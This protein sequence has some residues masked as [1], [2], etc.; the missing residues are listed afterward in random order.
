[1]II[2]KQQ[3]SFIF[4]EQDQHARISESMIK[5]WNKAYLPQS[6][7]HDSAIYAIQQHDVGWR[8]FDEEPFW[9]DQSQAPYNFTD[10]PTPAKTV[11]YTAGIE[12][13]ASADLYAGLLCSLHYTRFLEKDTSYYSKQFVD[14][15]RRRQQ[16]IISSLKQFDEE[17]L[18]IHLDLLQL[19]DNLS[20]FICLNKPGENT[21]PFFKNGIPLSAKLKG[22]TNQLLETTWQDKQTIQLSQL[23]FSSATTFTYPYK[24]VTKTAIYE[25][26]LISTYTQAPIK[27]IAVTF[28]QG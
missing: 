18:A 7:Y 5:H 24:Q 4:I 6:P 3:N 15:E 25:Q 1:M 14:Q 10:F 20:L 2:R 11:L 8:P 9:N 26:G 28:V 19:C 12:K 22:F 16:R 17:T 21:H 23:P 27:E 13:V